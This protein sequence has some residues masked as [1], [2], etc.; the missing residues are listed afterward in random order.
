M[1]VLARRRGT[2]KAENRALLG[3]TEDTESGTQW[4]HCGRWC[5]LP[6]QVQEAVFLRWTWLSC[7][8][9]QRT[10][11]NYQGTCEL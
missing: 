3:S 11:K 5:C 7:H 8:P 4:C 1:A 6:G 2:E 10:I 9:A